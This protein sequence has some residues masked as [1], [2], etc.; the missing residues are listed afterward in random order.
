MDRDQ[1]H[2]RCASLGKMADV[3]AQVGHQ[4]AAGG[5]H[6]RARQIQL[7]LLDRRTRAAQL[8][9]VVTGVAG[10]FLGLAQVGLGG[11]LLA[12]RLDPGGLRDLQ[13]AYRDGAAILGVQRFLTRRILVGL[14]AIGLCRLQRG[15]R[16]FHGG[17]GGID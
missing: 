3:G 11:L 4:T 10:G 8:G 6:L 16:C 5:D 17:H 13:P 14:D 15:A 7:G 1:G 12:M 2:R 9:I